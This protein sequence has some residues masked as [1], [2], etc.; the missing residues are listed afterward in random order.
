LRRTFFASRP[1]S[2]AKADIIDEAADLPQALIL[3]PQ[4]LSNRKLPALKD[5]DCKEDSVRR[6]RSAESI[7]RRR[8]AGVCDSLDV[9]TLESVSLL[10]SKTNKTNIKGKTTV[11]IANL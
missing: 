9:T 10:E 8:D 6:W 11:L 1:E 5:A 3:V 4:N 7:T 2:R